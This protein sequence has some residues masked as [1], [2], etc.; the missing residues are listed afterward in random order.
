[1]FNK[2]SK[3]IFIVKTLDKVTNTE[4]NTTI[5]AEIIDIIGDYYVYL[6]KNGNEFGFQLQDFLKILIKHRE[7]KNA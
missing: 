5:T 1:M 2:G 6:D 3:Y 4:R 7:I